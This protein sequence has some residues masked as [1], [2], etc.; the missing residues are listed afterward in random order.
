[1]VSKAVKTALA[2]VAF[3]APCPTPSASQ[4]Q[5][6]VSLL[7]PYHFSD[8][9]GGFRIGAVSGTGTRDDP[10][11]ISPALATAGAVTMV[12][13]AIAP[14]DARGSSPQFATG[15]IHLELDVSNRSGIPW[16]GLELELQEEF[17][18]PST[19]GDGLSFN[20]RRPGPLDAHAGAFASAHTDFEPH[21]RLLFDNG[22]LDADARTT[23]RVLITDTTPQPVF[24]LKLDPRIPAS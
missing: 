12:I 9:L 8:E 1:M 15:T 18:K 23:I 14:I 13:R 4:E 20:Q 17:A 10:L 22:A 24:Y 19:Y 3:L 7:P 2:G 5:P 21:D 11:R 16:I 6:A